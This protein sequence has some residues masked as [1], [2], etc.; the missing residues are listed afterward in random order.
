MAQRRAEL[1]RFQG[2]RRTEWAAVVVGL[3]MTLGVVGCAGRKPELVAPAV[4]VAPYGTAGSEVLW[5]VAPLRNESGT[6]DPDALLVSDQ[7]VRACEEVRGVRTVPL[8]RTLEAMRALQMPM[9]STPGDARRLAAALGADGLVVGTITAWDPYTPTVGLTLALHA[10]TAAML[11]PDTGVSAVDPR[12]LAAAATDGPPPNTL[13]DRPASVVS[14]NLD[15]KNH[16]VQM[17]VQS[18]ARGRTDAA[19]AMG[20]RRYTQSMELFTEFAAADLVKRLVNKEWIRY[21]P[22]SSAPVDHYEQTTN[23]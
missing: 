22:G 15:G 14:E 20:W 16:Q 21:A 5:V 13:G 9:V 7:L 10:R 6:T 18:Y 11:G 2:K 17:D 4:T 12:A 1:M 8:N 19:S 23:K 3:T